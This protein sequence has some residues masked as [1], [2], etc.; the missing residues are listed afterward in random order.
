M[1][2]ATVDALQPGGEGQKTGLPFIEAA[3][4]RVEVA[5]Q[6]VHQTLPPLPQGGG[7]FLLP[8]RLLPLQ[9]LLQLLQRQQL[10]PAGLQ[11]A[12]AGGDP[13][14]QIAPPITA[15]LHQSEGLEM[16]GVLEACQRLT[17][18]QV[19]LRSQLAAAQLCGIDLGDHTPVTQAPA[20]P[21]RVGP[22][23]SEGQRQRH[24]HH[25]GQPQAQG[26]EAG[27][28]HQQHQ[29]GQGNGKRIVEGIHHGWQGPVQN[30]G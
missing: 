26:G 4:G 2:Q 7:G 11:Q 19:G 16:G 8:G 27:Q 5:S 18:H 25:Q 20:P 21:T 24:R 17:A 14:R 30:A 22:Q 3:T 10:A 29:A 6:L 9:P 15:E 28:Q 23:G 1:A 12:P 13:A